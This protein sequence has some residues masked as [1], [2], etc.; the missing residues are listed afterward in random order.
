M[1]TFRRSGAIVSLDVA[2]MALDSLFG[3]DWKLSTPIDDAS[4]YTK[5]GFWEDGVGH[6]EQARLP[7]RC[8]GRP[9]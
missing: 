3:I 4:L 5:N 1:G 8:Y 9:A 6:M 7:H 2:Q